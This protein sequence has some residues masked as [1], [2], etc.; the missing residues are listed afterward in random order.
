MKLRKGRENIEENPITSCLCAGA[1]NEGLKASTTCLKDLSIIQKLMKKYL[2]IAN[3][4]VVIQFPMKDATGR[5]LK[6]RSI[7]SQ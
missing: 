4:P 5:Y 1:L 3:F 6:M 7:Y 2:R